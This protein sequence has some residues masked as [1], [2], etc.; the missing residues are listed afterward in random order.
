MRNN[1]IVVI[2]CYNAKRSIVQSINGI[3]KCLPEAKIIVIDD[4]SPDGSAK[5]VKR[6][7]S[8]NKAVKLIVRNDKG[9]RGSAIL[10]GFQEGLKDRTNEFFVEMDADLCHNPKYIPLL[11]NKCKTCDV[12]IASKYLEGSRIDGLSIKRK[13]F[14]KFANNYIKFVLNV[15][16]TDYTNGF[17]CYRRKALESIDLNNFK[18][19]GFIMLSEIAY[20]LYKRKNSFGEIPFDFY[21]N[22]VNKSNF[23]MKEVQ[24]AFM[25]VLKLKFNLI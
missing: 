17:R 11:V 3:S 22:D 6:N 14:S 1:I 13:I 21:F 8:N 4:N 9:G 16:I 15:P 25:T 23:N 24:E 5:L 10:R 19:K 2:P 7:F 20:K 18:S 12:A